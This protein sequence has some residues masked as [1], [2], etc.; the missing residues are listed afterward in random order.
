MVAK[1]RH[2]QSPQS[3]PHSK[4]CSRGTAALQGGGEQGLDREA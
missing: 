4:E 3:E 2:A 1:E